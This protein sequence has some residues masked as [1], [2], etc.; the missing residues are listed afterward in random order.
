[1][2]FR[3]I[4]DDDRLV[5]FAKYTNASLGR[6]KALYLNWARACG[7][8]SPQCQELNRLFSQ[9]VDGNRIK[10]PQKLEVAPLPPADSPKFILDVLHEGAMSWIKTLTIKSAR[11]NQLDGFD[12]DALQLLLNRDDISMSEFEFILLAHN[13]CFNN[14]VPFGDLLYIFDFTTLKPEQQAWVI[15]Q[16]PP[17][18]TAP[19][20][21]LNALCSSNILSDV[22]LNHFQMGSPLIRWKRVYDAPKQ[23]RLD[24]FLEAV[25][26]NIESFH[27][28]LIIFRP[29]DRL[30]LAIYIPRKVERHEDCLIEDSGRMFAFPTTQG[31]ERQSRLA[32]PTKKMYQVYCDG[33]VFQLFDGKRANSWVFMTRPGVNDEAYRN[34]KNQ[35]DRRRE[36]QGV[37]DKE[38]QSE[39]CVSVALDKFSRGLQR[40]I[41]RV[42]RA[43]ICAAVR[44][45]FS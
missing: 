9:C 20:L 29:D 30:C 35:G 19:A 18:Q 38:L 7:P 42:N 12:A 26:F 36:R 14:Q 4:T 27:R 3:P 10:I 45:R 13:W 16:L 39:V 41:G 43:A 1:M 24:T 15:N 23:D 33:N 37:I 31:P 22:D 21:I 8:M 17:S 34:T 28:K 11:P 44:P 6:V 25:A 2:L 5:Y 40:H 32:L